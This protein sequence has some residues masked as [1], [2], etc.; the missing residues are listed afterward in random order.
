MVIL[1]KWPEFYFGSNYFSY[2]FYI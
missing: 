1:N 2:Q